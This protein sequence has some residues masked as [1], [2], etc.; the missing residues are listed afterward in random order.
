V[1]ATPSG[2]LRGVVTAPHPLRVKS[3]IRHRASVGG[4]PRQLP[5]DRETG[6]FR[7]AG[8]RI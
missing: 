1:K 8:G 4:N 3:G 5:V 7:P 2:S 6:A